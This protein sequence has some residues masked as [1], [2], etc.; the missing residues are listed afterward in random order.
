M[1]WLAL[2]CPTLSL[3]CVLRRWPGNLDPALA[4]TDLDG[5]R[6]FIAT[7]TRTAQA[8]GVLAG[9]AIAT[10]LALLPELVL[11]ARNLEEEAR[12]LKEAALVA[13]RFTPTVALRPQGLV[14]E[15]SA[16]LRLFGGRQALRR[17]LGSA[18]RHQ[19]LQVAVAEAPTPHGAWLLAQEVARRRQAGRT[20]RHPSVAAAL[21]ALPVAH[22]ES[23]RP[24]L[25]RFVGIGCRFVADLRR[26]PAQG[27]ARR[28]GPDLVDEID[29][30]IGARPDPQIV[31][32]APS[33]FDARIEL[34]A[35]VESA[36][37]LLVAA[38]RLL[39]QLAG[40]LAARR[41]AVRGYV[42]VLHHERWTRDDIP[43]TSVPIQL[44]T[45]G[46]ELERLVALARERLGR[47]ELPAPVLELSLQVP[48]IVAA[49]E[50][51]GMLFPDRET[52]VDSFARLLEKMTAR[53]GRDA[54][55]RIERVA[56]HRPERAWREVPAE[57]AKPA[58]S[59]GRAGAAFRRPTKLPTHR[60]S[61][62][63]PT[64]LGPRPAWL[65]SD[66][67]VLEVRQHQPY[68]AALPLDR[69]A[70]PERIETGW[71]D[72]APVTR[73]YFIAENAAGQLVWIY[74]ERL[75]VSGQD[76]WYLHGVF[77]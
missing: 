36:E 14:M 40:W 13:L 50:H 15:I 58:A 23:A 31:F 71:W 45:P 39:A 60:G 33:R 21:D 48:E 38:E 65:L 72:D 9:Q 12:A 59:L 68:H 47:F 5:S 63:L 20:V 26:L 7:A 37:A 10:A 53:L 51:D 4:V 34:M 54:M 76:L 27:L 42:L 74:R 16:S 18:M 28:F 25:D 52:P 70:G 73:D 67:Q 22:L 55:T 57:V 46:H 41:A 6:R 77:G 24:Y 11:V 44:A 56:D 19:G 30:A 43:P 29:R 49:D 8:A 62:T 17:Q 61:S 2:H 35:R 75:P 69:L 64:S 32:A 3:D 66:P 1:L